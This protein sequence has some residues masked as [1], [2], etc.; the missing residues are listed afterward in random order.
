LWHVDLL[1]ESACEIGNCTAATARQQLANNRGLVFSAQSAK[2]QLN[3]NRG[4]VFS[5]QSVFSGRFSGQRKSLKESPFQE[6]DSLFAMWFKHARG[7]NTVISSRLL[8]DK[9]HTLQQGSVDFKASN[10]WTETDGFK[11]QHSVEY[12]TISEEGKSAG[13]S[14]MREWR[15]EQLLKIT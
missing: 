2:Q 13:S 11:K 6:L 1:L 8:R 14:M 4:T 7:S 12:K 10:G 5:V 15:N 9:A 3:S